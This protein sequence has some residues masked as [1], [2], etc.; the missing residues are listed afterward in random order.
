MRSSLHSMRIFFVIPAMTIL[1]PFGSN[2]SWTNPTTDPFH[3]SQPNSITVRRASRFPTVST[4]DQIKFINAQSGFIGGDG[5][6]YSTM[7]HGTH[8]QVSYRG[9]STIYS[10][11]F[12][13][14]RILG[15]KHMFA[16]NSKNRIFMLIDIAILGYSLGGRGV[17]NGGNIFIV[18]ECGA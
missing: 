8:W 17:G 3:Y 2:F 14:L 7:D 9:Q 16:H 12:L 5:I 11:D 10:F 15:L 18:L 6:I 13:A 1:A 4:L